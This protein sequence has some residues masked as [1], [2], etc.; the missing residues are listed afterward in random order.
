MAIARNMRGMSQT[1]LAVA[2]GDR[3]DQ[4]VISRVESGKRGLL[5][6]GLYKA[7][8]ALGVSIDYLFGLTNDPTPAATLSEASHP[9]S[10]ETVKVAEVSAVA[11]SRTV[12]YDETPTGWVP[13]P[14][15]W[16]R[17][18]SINPANCHLVKFYGDSM[19]PVLPDGCTILV[20]RSSQLPRDKGVYLVDTEEGVLVKRVLQHDA[21]GWVLQSDNRTMGR[22]PLSDYTR[23]IGE[24]KWFLGPLQ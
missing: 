24:V 8:L 1:D 12:G 18:R 21:L 19:L 6:G 14:S 23:I 11:N 15:K 10:L 16:F 4:S 5:V 2:M 17:E 9:G 22:V 3:Y 13:L 7:A 20:D